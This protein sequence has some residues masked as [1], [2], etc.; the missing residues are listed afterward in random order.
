MIPKPTRTTSVVTLMKAGPVDFVFVFL[1]VL[2]VV[3]AIVCTALM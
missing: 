2:V 1:T 3:I